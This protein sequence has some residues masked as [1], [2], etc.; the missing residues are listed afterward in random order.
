LPRVELDIAIRV[1]SVPT[2]RKH[3][4]KT[5]LTEHYNKKHF[6]FM[7]YTIYMNTYKTSNTILY[8][9]KDR[10]VQL[11]NKDFLA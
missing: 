10:T 2:L 5:T 4:S 1:K 7:K 3:H 8:C 11:K 6:Y 9:D